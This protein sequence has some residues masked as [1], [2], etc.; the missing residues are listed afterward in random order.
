MSPFLKTS[1]DGEL[2]L[3]HSASPGIP[4]GVA[5]RMDLPP[6][7]VGEGGRMHA[8]TLGCPHCGGVVLLNPMRK[9]ERAN[10]FKCNSYICDGC[11]AVMSDPNYIHRTFAEIAEMVQSGKWTV[12]GPTCNPILTPTEK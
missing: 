1:R 11:A 9:R 6:E 8:A 7:L 4:P 2:F 10:C 3:D 12:S 5:Q